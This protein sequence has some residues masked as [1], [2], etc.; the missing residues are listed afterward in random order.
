MMKRKP[1]RTE[2]GLLL[3]TMGEYGKQRQMERKAIITKPDRMAW[4]FYL[5]EMAGVGEQVNK[6]LC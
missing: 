5:Q 4:T 2:E 6:W 1:Q 3:L